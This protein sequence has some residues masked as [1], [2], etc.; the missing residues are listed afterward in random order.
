MNVHESEQLRTALVAKGFLETKDINLAEIIIFNTCCIRDTAEQKIISHIGEVGHI[1][2]K[3]P[4]ILLIII[5][6]LSAKGEK[7][8]RQKFPF[9]DLILGTNKNSE[10]VEYLTQESIEIKSGVGHNIIIT[11][12]C[13]NFCSYCIVPYVRGKEFSRDIDDIIQEFL[14]IK[15]KD[16][17]KTIFLLGQNVNSYRC[18]KTSTDFVGLLDKLCAIDGD[19]TLN[20][21]SSHPKD[22]S[23][24]LIDCIARNK[25][26][27]R[28]IHLP[29]Q[30]GCDKILRLMNRNY[31]VQ[32][33]INKVNLLR[34]KIPEI[35]ITTDIICGFPSETEC[36]FQETIAT[37]KKIQFNAAFI[38]PYSKRSGTKAAE[39]DGQ[40]DSKTKKARATE[41]INIQRE[42]SNSLDFKGAK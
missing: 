23:L 36:D 22:F 42:I 8:L 27:E 14:D 17:N 40:L 41:L 10:L 28:N 32:E 20:F 11:H 26:I 19:F 2:R 16:N 1:K 4:D 38:F 34:E 15:I 35:H 5:G 25:N 29:I 6:C 3:N 39:L 21:L 7:S 33:Y 24:G 18:P 31:T 9:I 13:E 30:S 12:G 37:V